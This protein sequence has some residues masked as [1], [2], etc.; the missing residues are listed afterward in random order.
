[1]SGFARPR[2][3]VLDALRALAL[4]LPEGDVTTLEE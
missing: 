2:T 4:G 1:L 3:G